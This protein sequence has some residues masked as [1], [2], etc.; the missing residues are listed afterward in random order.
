MTI[1]A[2]AESIKAKYPAYK[3]MDNAVL[4]QKIIAKYPTY[5]SQV[6]GFSP[7]TKPK[8]DLL[9][10]ASDIGG[11]LFPGTKQIGESLGTVAA[12]GG[13]AIKGDFSGAQEILSTQKTVPELIG[14]YTAAGASLLGSTGA[15]TGGGLISKALQAAGIGAA[16]GGGKA[17][18]EGGDLEKVAKEATVGGTV[19][20]GTSL[21]FGGA[22]AALK[23]FRALPQR[24]IRSA[25]GQSKNEILAGKDITK[26]V[27]ENKKIGTSDQLIRGSQQ[28]IDQADEIIKTNLASVRDKTI[29]VRGIV[30]DI[31]DSVNKSGGEI[32][33]VGVRS[34]LESLAPQVKKTLGKETLTLAEAN[35]LRSQLDK[36]LG[37]RAFINA[38]LPFNKGILKDFTNAIREQ[39]KNSAPEGTRAAFNTLAKEIALRD[40]LI[41]KSAGMSR[42]QVIGLGDLISGTLGGA[43]GGIP[44]ALAT[45]GAKRVAESTIAKTGTA[46]MVD[47][48][49]KALTPVLAGL[50]PAA[51][52]AVINAIVQAFSVAQE[53]QAQDQ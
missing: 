29:P 46:V 53:D 18:A 30:A 33:E 47:N 41:K 40:L 7:E 2:F 50:E 1:D 35:Q 28:A 21:A 4:A 10:T 32:D 19:G 8:K 49:D 3:D 6:E 44:G 38:Q 31:A 37:N 39:V 20:A 26:Y 45:A 42:N 52:T 34:I 12:A 11:M 16:I 25:T 23:S 43:V 13:R 5:A 15:G 51:Q 17:A 27:L 14:A 24:L 48:L 22:E 36:T 9:Q